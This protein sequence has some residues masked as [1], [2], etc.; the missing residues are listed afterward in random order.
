MAL[1]ENVGGSGDFKATTLGATQSYSL[2]SATSP[3]VLTPPSGKVIRLD[4][5]ISSAQ[6][7]DTSIVVDGETA[8]TGDLYA[9][10]GNDGSFNIS[11]PNTD[12][13]NSSIQ[14]AGVKSPITAFD[15]DQSISISTTSASSVLIYYSVSYGDLL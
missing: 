3:L 1:T 9:F 6:I 12:V 5:L 2:S 15:K 7:N 4:S 10:T 11:C 14:H 13:N 8:I